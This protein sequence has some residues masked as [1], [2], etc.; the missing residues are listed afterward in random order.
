MKL[1]VCALIAA[2]VFLLSACPFAW[3]TGESGPG[4]AAPGNAG[5]PPEA[6]ASPETKTSPDPSPPEKK[7]DVSAAPP[8]KKP[9]ARG[10]VWH[11]PPAYFDVTYVFWAGVFIYDG[12]MLDVAT[13]ETV[14]YDGRDFATGGLPP[15][16]EWLIDETKKL[17]AFHGTDEEYAP[18]DFFVFTRDEFE[19][20]CEERESRWRG[21]GINRLRMFRQIDTDK[22]TATP[23]DDGWFSGYLYDLSGAYTGDKTALAFG[24]DFVTGFI[25]DNTLWEA[26]NNRMNLFAM[27]LDGLWGVVDKHGETVIPHL[28]ESFY[29]IDDNS[30]F[31][32]YEGLYGILNLEESRG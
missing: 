12:W 25:Y 14:K 28:F 21:G 23:Y 32:Q 4:D 22:V 7:P 18:S 5:T 11:T 1:R 2:M 16:D 15:P 8:D 9:D 19:A 30:A 10:L 20:F 6:S 27:R 31:A 3:E 17:Y 29:F 13:G 26:V 24:T